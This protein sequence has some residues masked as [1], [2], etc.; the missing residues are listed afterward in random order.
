MAGGGFLREERAD[1]Q[2]EMK[3]E[4]EF[5]DG[6]GEGHVCRSLGL[7]GDEN[8]LQLEGT[9]EHVYWQR[10]QMWAKSAHAGGVWTILREVRS[11]G[12]LLAHGTSWTCTWGRVHWPGSQVPGFPR[13]MNFFPHLPPSL[14]DGLSLMNES[15][16]RTGLGKEV[17]PLV[18]PKS[19]KPS[20]HFRHTLNC[21]RS[22]WL[23]G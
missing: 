10:L 7:E 22:S 12:H 20:A 14:P 21:T 13:Q 18:I 8:A 15:Q 19:G 2:A 23:M 11:H 3:Q 4:W 1:D 6:E 17:S 16:T 9:W 5:P